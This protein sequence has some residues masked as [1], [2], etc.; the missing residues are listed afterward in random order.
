MLEKKIIMSYAFSFIQYLKYF[1]K[2]SNGRGHGVHSPFVYSFIIS[3]LNKK[4][5]YSNTENVNKYDALVQS[6]ISYYTPESICIEDALN[7]EQ[8]LT[9]ISNLER[10]DLLYLKKIKNSDDLWMFFNTVMQKVNSQSILIFEG[11]HQNSQMQ[12]CWENIKMNQQ[13]R[14]TIDVFK[15]GILFFRTEQREKENF[16]IRF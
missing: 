16:I 2:A 3:V 1:F 10:V 15:L 6:M 5:Q 9:K 14:L 7:K 13:V 11:I 8:A 4:N 12:A